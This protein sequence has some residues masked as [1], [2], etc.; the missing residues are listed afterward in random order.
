M[1]PK[2]SIGSALILSKVDDH[3]RRDRSSLKA[4]G[5]LSIEHEGDA[6]EAVSILHSAPPDVVLLDTTLGGV[7][8]VEFLRQ[9]RDDPSLKD[10]PMVMDT[11]DSRREL[12][13]DAIAA[14]C[15]GYVI[16]PYSLDTFQRHISWA[17]RTTSVAEIEQIQLAEAQDLLS[18]G[19]L[20][21]AIE[22]FEEIVSEQN[23]AQKYYDIGMRALLKQKYGQAIISFKKAVKLNDLYAEAYQGLA[24]AYKGKGDLD[25]Y[26][27]FLQ[28]AAEVYAQFDR[29]EEAKAIFIEILKHDAETPNPYNTLGVRLRKNG[30]VTGA[31][32]AY[33]Q[34]IELTP[35]DENIFFNI[36]KA[37]FFMG[38]VEP[39]KEAVVKALQISPGFKEGRKLYAKLFNKEWPVTDEQLKAAEQAAAHLTSVRDE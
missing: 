37:H 9:A 15:A 30:D 11:A 8:A 29:M 2:P 16:R 31:L 36:A 3:V 13:L 6:A 26:T 14:G 25:S 21:E 22:A 39:A 17:L 35:H 33:K 24:E 10:I 20:D 1:Q 23:E 38:E 5:A 28:K 34:A 27:S 4:L 18:A 32:R 7:D 12:V 19:S